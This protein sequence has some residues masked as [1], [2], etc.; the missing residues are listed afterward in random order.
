MELKDFVKA[1]VTAVTS[2]VTELQSELAPSGAVIAP[3]SG[4]PAVPGG[5][6]GSDLFCQVRGEPRGLIRE[7]RFDLFVAE[8]ENK[9]ASGG[10]RINVIKAGA[11][12]SRDTS[13]Y[14]RVSFSL[15]VVLPP[16]PLTPPD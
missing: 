3:A 7:I 10:I 6:S 14:S 1:T 15:P 5:Y 2:A 16:A 4:V 12:A 8:S 9:S 13:T 11:G